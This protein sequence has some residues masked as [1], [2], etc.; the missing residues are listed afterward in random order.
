AVLFLDLDE[1]KLINDSFGHAAG[2]ELLRIIGQRLRQRVRATDTVARLGGDEFVVVLGRLAS[3]DAAEEMAQDLV[4]GLSEPIDLIDHQK[5]YISASV[6]ISVFPVDGTEAG[7]LLQKADT[8]LYEAK[9]NGRKAFRRYSTALTATANKRI[10]LDSGM[11][12]A[13]E[14]DEFVL[15]YQ[16]LVSLAD[17]SLTGCEALIRWQ[18]PSR[19]LVPPSDFI[20]I[21]EETGFIL[22]LGEWVLR[23]ACEQLVRW[24]SA[25]FA[26]PRVAIN[27]SARQFRS[28]D[29]VQNLTAILKQTGVA[30]AS[31]ELE[32]TEGAL[33]ENSISAAATLRALKDLGV[34]LALDDFGTGYSSLAY[35]KTFPIDKLKIDRSFV[36]SIPSDQTSCEIATVII[37]LAKCL[38]LEVLAEGIES[39]SQRDMLKRHGCD[40]GQGFLFGRPAMPDQFT[41]FVTGDTKRCEAVYIG[42][43]QSR[44]AVEL[45]E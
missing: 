41:R 9:R 8:A 40:T 35:L 10:Q 6:G 14:R 33:M 5:I 15:L 32:I 38:N 36:Q 30:P 20:P 3:L 22:P 2:D 37:G 25:G 16:P 4:K 29:L 23:T 42:R 11:R 39:D 45:R 1:F 44:P 21:A 43:S 12:T 13:L 28:P 34:Q 18:D 24:R 19:G 7:Q 26:V 17:G 31:I 27:V